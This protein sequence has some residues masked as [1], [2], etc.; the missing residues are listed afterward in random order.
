MSNRT[1]KIV[2]AGIAPSAAAQIA[3]ADVQVGLTA[4]GTTQLTALAVT[5]D[6]VEVTTAALN[7]GAM[8]FQGPVPGPGDCQYIFNGGANPLSVY[9]PVGGQINVLGVNAAFSVPAGKGLLLRCFNATTFHTL[10]GA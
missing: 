1:V 8:A 5:G 6:N 4:A 7:S 10:L 9:P 2:G 3:G